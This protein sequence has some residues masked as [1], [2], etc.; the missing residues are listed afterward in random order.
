[1][2]GTKFK[3]SNG[4][5]TAPMGEEDRVY[6]LPIRR[7]CYDGDPATLAVVSCWE[8]TWKERLAILFTGR[9]WFV[10][11]GPTHPPIRIEGVRPLEAD[12]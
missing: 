5:L 2:I 1:M 3:E 6:D 11:W 12:L 7:I 8:A 10:C 4:K 9:T